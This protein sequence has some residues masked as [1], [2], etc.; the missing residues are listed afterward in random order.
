ML[1]SPAVDFFTTCPYSYES[2]TRLLMLF[3]CVYLHASLWSLSHL[4]R[5]EGEGSGPPDWGTFPYDPVIESRSSFLGCHC[6]KEI[7]NTIM[8][9][10]KMMCNCFFVTWVIPKKYICVDAVR[11][12]H[13]V[14]T[15]IHLQYACT[16]SKLNS[17]N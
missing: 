10:L 16:S 3:Y 15:C 13:T 11:H 14:H 5:C 7:V 8:K 12:S 1:F 9:Y 4:S 2:N 6:R 17:K